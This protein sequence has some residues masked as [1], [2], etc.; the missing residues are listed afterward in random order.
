[1]YRPWFSFFFTGNFRKNFLNIDNFLKMI[2]NI[3]ILDI[4]QNCCQKLGLNSKHKVA[5]LIYDGTRPIN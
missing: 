4:S 3:F 1:M 2:P 5:Q